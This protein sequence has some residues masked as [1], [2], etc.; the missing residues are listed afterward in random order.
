MVRALHLAER[1]TYSFAIGRANTDEAATDAHTAMV[2]DDDRAATTSIRLCGKFS[3]T[4]HGRDVTREVGH[5]QGRAVLACLLLKGASGASRDELIH[6]L[7]PD[8]AHS[9][10]APE[11]GL[12]VVISRLRTAL[13]TATIAGPPQLSIRLEPGAEV[14]VD[15]AR[16]GLREAEQALAAGE[17]GRAR[18]AVDA[19][20]AGFD[21]PLLPGLEGEWIDEQRIRFEDLK[22]RLRRAGVQAGIELGGPELDRVV[23]EAARLVED[24]PMSET[25]VGLLMRALAARGDRSNALE[26]YET[27]RVRLRDEIGTA[28]S[29]TLAALHADLLR[30]APAPV[31]A[32]RP[33]RARPD[34]PF[35]GRR[36]ELELLRERWVALEP[37]R[38]PI[39]LLEG[40][41]GI[42]KTALADRFAGLG[43]KAVLRGRCDEDPIVPYQPFVEALGESLEPPQ[44]SVPPEFQQYVMFDGVAQRLGDLSHARP[45]LLV[46][47]DLQWADKPTVKLLQHLAR[48]ELRIML[49]GTYRG[50]EVG[51]GHPL[52]EL[53]TEQRRQQR[54]D[55][56]RLPGLTQDETDALV[57]TRID[58]P[59]ADLVSELWEQTVGNPLFIEETLRS[60]A[61]TADGEPVTAR[62]LEE[63]GV[64]EG[65][66]S[67]IL[68][69]LD[70][71]EPEPREA[72]RA[73][74]AVGHVFDLDVVAGAARLSVAD[75]IEA[76]DAPAMGGLVEELE[77][78]RFAFAHAIVRMAIYEDLS[79]TRRAQLHQRIGTLLEEKPRAPGQAA[80]VAHHLARG[81]GDPARVVRH[82]VRAGQEAARACAYE[83][84]AGHFERAV[85]AL[86]P[87]RDSR[88]AKV[89]LRW[90]GVLSRAGHSR[91]AAAKFRAA[92]DTARVSGDAK[93]LATAALGVGQRYWEA[94]ITD[95]TYRGQL[96]EALERLATV[97]SDR[98][99][100]LLS[101][102]L[103]ARLAEHLAF[104]PG[105]QDRARELSADAVDTARGLDEPDTLITALMARHV[106]LLH[107]D[108]VEERL[109]LIEEVLDLRGRHR[110]L[111]AEAR[112]WRLYDL[113]ELGRLDEARAEA[114][115]L[116]E[117]SR[118]LRQPLFQH[119]A[120]AWE[121]VFAE[122]AG[123]VAETERLTEESFVLGT[124]AQAY[125]ARS[126][127]AA[128]LFALYRWQGRLDELREDVHG[129][130]GGRTSLA[131]W[132]SAL[133][134]HKILTGDLD[135]G[136]RDAHMLATLFDRVPRDFFWLSAATVLAEAVHLCGDDEA[137]A[138]LYAAL[139]PH[140]ERHTQHSF[141]ACWGSVRRP[142]GLLAETLGRRDEAEAHLRGALAAN[143]A[144]RAPVLIAATECDLGEL[145]LS[146][147]AADRERAAEL[148]ATA[149]ARVRP[150]GLS[151]LSARAAALR[152]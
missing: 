98:Q 142:L 69:R 85:D 123:D 27:L 78:Y 137:A 28:P 50:G 144:S 11:R 148:G 93:L 16:R 39:V 66:R 87:A 97:E 6:V 149:E 73:A 43:E 121:G 31:R 1:R 46:V 114:L 41:A 62:T 77:E 132:R 116:G 105:E 18:A 100:K 152:A 95:P 115:Q 82:E 26:V 102:R 84:A 70:A 88:R 17:F 13:E 104:V 40:E 140:A 51:R 113:C 58:D 71:L 76:L 23:D 68:R 75:V 96:E 111:A 37:E 53:M 127:R 81:G 99:V 125:D 2:M 9:P 44:A 74:A 32:P 126:I 60:L 107:I 122:L 42:G 10:E 20:I 35:V 19:A 83:E 141:A 49:V 117:R 24:E 79:G 29:P 64:A 3:V 21:G 34:R 90:A 67:V 91:Q 59:A 146:S 124:R 5:K 151:V 48:R 30:D 8:R 109:G 110:E 61:E 22:L 103:S 57:K 12:T 86:G 38:W 36:S 92:A 135:E 89:E 80:A 54:L 130:G 55:V 143:C 94:N 112:Q 101:T 15:V 52:R 72:L 119:V 136:S 138:P 47:D 120:V 133:A 131:A 118:E 63:M 145:L 134:L 128:K 33:A 108:H 139:A 106:T 147:D 129:L 4:V 150:L 7:W 65:V 56:L 25:A 45:L 14:D